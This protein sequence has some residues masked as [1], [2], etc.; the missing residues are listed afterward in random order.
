MFSLTSTI[1]TKYNSL[2]KKPNTLAACVNDLEQANMNLWNR[3]LNL[4][5][6]QH[7]VLKC[8][9]ADQP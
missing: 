4:R 5:K 2:Q 3:I 9:G 6:R 7:L 8:Y 1:I